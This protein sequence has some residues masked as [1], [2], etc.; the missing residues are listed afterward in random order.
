MITDLTWE[1]GIATRLFPKT[2][3]RDVLTITDINNVH[4]LRYAEKK[5]ELFGLGLY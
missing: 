3:T 5:K 1:M 4:G 2:I